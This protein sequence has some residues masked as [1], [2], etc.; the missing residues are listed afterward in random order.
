MKDPVEVKLP[1]CN[2]L[3][4]AIEGVV[5]GLCIIFA[6]AD[7]TNGVIYSFASRKG[8]GPRLFYHGVRSVC[9]SQQSTNTG[10]GKPTLTIVRITPADLGE[11]FAGWCH[12]SFTIFTASAAKEE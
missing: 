10:Q 12:I 6:F 3:Y 4:F 11:T 7:S 8:L 2:A 5:N 9:T 1:G